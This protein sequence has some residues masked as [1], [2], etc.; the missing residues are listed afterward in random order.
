MNSVACPPMDVPLS[1][2]M[3]QSIHNTFC[4][5]VDTAAE[6]P[7]TPNQYLLHRYCPYTNS[8]CSPIRSAA[9]LDTNSKV[10][11]LGEGFLRIP[12]ED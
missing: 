12:S 9:A 3:G 5:Q 10:S 2:M 4:A 7:V 11:P 1:Q 8:F 6:T